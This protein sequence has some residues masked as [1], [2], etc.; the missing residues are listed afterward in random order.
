MDDEVTRLARSCPQC[1]K[2]L[3][4]DAP[5]G[6]CAACL[7][8]AGT[9]TL[10]RSTIDD[11]VTVSSMSGVGPATDADDAHTIAGQQWGSYRIGRLLGRGGMGEVYEAEQTQTGRRLALKV[12]RSRLRNAEDRARFLREGQ[13]AASVSHPHTV[14]IFGS[15]E[16]DG[17]PVISMELLPGGTLKD[18]VAAQGPLPPAEAVAA[19]LDIV[20]GLD[21]AQ[22][23]GILHRDIKP[24]NCFIDAEGAVKVGDFGLSIST[25]ARDVRQDLLTE[26]FQG[27]P[28][29][30]PPEQLR[31]EPLDVRADIY[32]VGATLYYLLTGRP[33]FDAPDLRTLVARVTGE[34][35]VSPRTLGREVPSGLAGVVLR[36]LSKSPAGRPSS[37]A[38]LADALRPYARADEVPAPP[39]LRVMAGVVDWFIV[40][41]PATVW[42]AATTDLT[43]ASAPTPPEAGLGS[44]AWL[45]SLVYFLVFEMWSNATPGKRLFGLRVSKHGPR[46]AR[47]IAVRTAVFHLPNLLFT[48]GTLAIG[49]LPALGTRRLSGNVVLDGADMT[50][51][52]GLALVL[53]MIALLFVTARGRNGWAGLHERASGTRV[54]ARVPARRHERAPL[55]P[56]PGPSGS[57]DRDGAR[58]GPFVVPGHLAHR[59][60]EA[61]LPGFDPLLRREVWIHVVP[62][63][64]PPIDSVRRDVSRVSRLHWL[65]GRRSPTENW[66]AFEAPDGAPLPTGDRAPTGWP[67]LKSRLLDLANELVAGEQ[68]GST[69]SL[70]LDRVWIR[71]DG[72]L[73]LLDFAPPSRPPGDQPWLAPAALLT[74]VATHGA[75]GTSPSAFPLTARALIDAW[76]LRA[77]ATL[78]EARAALMATLSSP[79]RV[80]RRRRALPIALAAVPTIFL[81][82]F[83]TAVTLPT[84]YRFFGP[85]TTEMLELLEWVYQSDSGRGGPWADAAKRE[86]AATYLAGRHRSLMLDESF[87]GSPLMRQLAERLQPVA[88][89]VAGEHAAPSDGDLARAA[90]ILRPDLTRR[91]AQR[92]GGFVEMGGVILTALTALSLLLTMAC[93]LASAG[94]VRGGIL[95]RLLGLAVVDR[96]GREIGRWRSLARAMAAWSP[97]IVWLAYLAASPRVQGFVPVPASPLVGTTTTLVLLGAGAIW[98]IARPVRGPHDRLVG[99]WVV[100]R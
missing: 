36:C 38:A 56:V 86:A 31:G 99:T 92:P 3:A 94:I 12:L 100:P 30:A 1:R 42:R 50:A 39:G 65:T 74:A 82:L 77:P 28:Q 70:G 73:V 88:A 79:D 84:M 13:L 32:A 40:S 22:S 85:E 72:R 19:V 90:V 15:E 24:S 68:D 60:R 23:A 53:M 80:S 18:K 89:R 41:M 34:A 21:A 35:P 14:Y 59:V 44:W 4:A 62:P 29:F 17:V 57:R 9:E 51:L 64:T 2:A 37:Y 46:P 76:T 93:G 7:L 11:A 6:L 55:A 95:T 87:W 78:A 75:R 97:A 69:A 66:D 96:S 26:G 81:G 67:A 27:T 98:T 83:T 8:T 48:L 25:L 5:E 49:P 16:I 61:T 58:L 52:M 33:P 71:R 47:Q 63:G 45:A 91:A 10:T 43:V 20:G 54:V